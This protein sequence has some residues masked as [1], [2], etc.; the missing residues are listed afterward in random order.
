[1]D[2]AGLI[3]AKGTL[4]KWQ[5][6]GDLKHFK[7]LT[8][9][10]PVIMGRK[11]FESIGSKPL[12]GRHNIVVGSSTISKQPELSSFKNFPDA[13]YNALCSI[14]DRSL[15]EEVMVIGGARVF[16]LALP[17]SDRI[18]ITDIKGFYGTDDPDDVYFPLEKS[19]LEKEFF[20]IFEEP[21]PTHTFRTYDR[22]KETLSDKNKKANF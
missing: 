15:E 12:P 2:E 21:H 10:K 5:A 18:Y 22:K 4:P 1:M 17:I 19:D 20:L 6:P 8:I 11:T 14:Q 7:S 13:L 9:N 3:G 16:Q